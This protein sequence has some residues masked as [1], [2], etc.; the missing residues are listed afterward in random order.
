MVIT[1]E[2]FHIRAPIES[3]AVRSASLSSQIRAICWGVAISIV[4]NAVKLLFLEF[5]F[6]VITFNAFAAAAIGPAV[7]VEFPVF[8]NV[9]NVHITFRDRKAV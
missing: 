3:V 1:N 9:A 7:V 5:E 6:A 2:P 8:I 4:F